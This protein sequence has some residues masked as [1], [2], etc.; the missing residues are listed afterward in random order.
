MHSSQWNREVK[1][2][3]EFLH[4]VLFDLWRRMQQVQGVG[5]MA[6]RLGIGGPR[7]AAQASKTPIFDGLFGEA[8]L[9]AV[10]GQQLWLR[11]DNLGKVQLEL[12]RDAS[13]KFLAL[14]A[15]QRAVRR[16][17]HQRVFDV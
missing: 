2:K 17:P 9:R 14:A 5:K 8:R 13:M 15:Q 1:R 12:G 16:I 11:I 6:Y 7:H 3:I 4:V 10:M